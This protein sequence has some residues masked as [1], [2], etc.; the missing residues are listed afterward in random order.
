MTLVS[1]RRKR[2]A[3]QKLHPALAQPW[4]TGSQHI[5]QM[6]GRGFMRAHVQGNIKGGRCFSHIRYGVHLCHR[7]CIFTITVGPCGWHRPSE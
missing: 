3:P 7:A 4:G 2:C 6:G 1:A 5:L